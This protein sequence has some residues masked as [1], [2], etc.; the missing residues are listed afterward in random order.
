MGK[1]IV[2]SCSYVAEQLFH[3][4]EPTLFEFLLVRLKPIAILVLGESREELPVGIGKSPEDHKA[5]NLAWSAPDLSILD[6]IH[7]SPLW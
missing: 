3:R 7:E 2:D 1:A 4:C 6:P 5:R